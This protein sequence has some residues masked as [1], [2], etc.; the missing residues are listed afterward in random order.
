MSSLS[1]GNKDSVSINDFGPNGFT[2]CIIASVCLRQVHPCLPSKQ[3]QK[4]ENEIYRFVEILD[5]DELRK[6][7]NLDLSKED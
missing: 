4:Y 1:I 7:S 5:V 2:T 3:K 6:N